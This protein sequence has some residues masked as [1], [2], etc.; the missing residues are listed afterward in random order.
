MNLS[1]CAKNNVSWNREIVGL[2]L[3]LD[4][5]TTKLH[6]SQLDLNSAERSSIVLKYLSATKLWK[7]TINLI[8][9]IW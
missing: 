7:W 6:K 3:K 5:Q 1:F 4:A 9:L 2:N 8:E